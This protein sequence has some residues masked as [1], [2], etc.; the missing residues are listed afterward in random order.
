MPRNATPVPVV[1]P[2]TLDSAVTLQ[3]LNQM[4]II[5][6]E[7][8]ERVFALA[9]KLGYAGALTVGGVEDEIRFYQHRTVEAML[10]LG[11]RLLILKEVSPHGE[12]ERRAELLGF[13]MSSAQSF[14]N[15]ARK[16]SKSPTVGLLAS[17]VKEPPA[18]PRQAG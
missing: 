16:V 12:F 11:K 14:M 6:N 1:K 15:A 9:Q 18:H 13:A 7:T 2:E 8:E 5:T 17:Q 3:P 4:A 10:E